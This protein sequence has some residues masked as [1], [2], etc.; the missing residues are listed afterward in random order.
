LQWQTV[1]NLTTPTS[2]LAA[3]RPVEQQE[4]EGINGQQLYKQ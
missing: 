1:I 3:P 2:H 4:M